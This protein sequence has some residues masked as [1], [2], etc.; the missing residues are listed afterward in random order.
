MTTEATLNKFEEKMLKEVSPLEQ[1]SIAL[2]EKATQLPTVTD[3]A[4]LGR[5]IAVKKEINAHSKLIKDSRMALTR[6][7]DDMKKTIMSREAEILLPLEKAKS[8]VADKILSYEEEQ[9]RIQ[10]EEEKRITGIA[11]SLKV[12]VWTL[13]YPGEV[14][15]EGEL[16]KKKFADLSL[17]DQNNADI[18][19]I[20]K[21]S[22][23]ALVTRKTNLEEEERQR[24]ERERLAK[25]AEKQSAERAK[26]ERE[27]AEIDRKEREIQAERERQ[28]RELERQELERQAEEKRKAD[29]A[30]EKARPKSNIATITEFE[31]EAP[32]LV[33][34][35]Y[36]SPDEKLIRAAIKSGV[37]EIAGVRIFQTKKVR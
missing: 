23:D 37:T 2:L 3:N 24:V 21:R 8:N 33:E 25:E 22:V 35:M 17:A 18:K 34:R 11:E 10:L 14:D 31:I 36:C 5:A 4:T 7:L 9:E 12:N 6:P 13:N 26:L 19:L 30:A 16:L 1:Q 20:F 32:S 29:I 15:A 28:Q 27:R